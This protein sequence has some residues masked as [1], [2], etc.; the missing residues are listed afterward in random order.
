M[1]DYD[2]DGS[3]VRR[4]KD[5]AVMLIK[6]VLVRQAAS[7]SQ[8]FHLLVLGNLILG[9]HAFNLFEAIYHQ[10]EILIIRLEEQFHFDLG[11]SHEL[12]VIFADPVEFLQ[13]NTIFNAQL[14]PL[15]PL[16]VIIRVPDCKRMFDQGHQNIVE[17][18]PRKGAVRRDAE[19]PAKFV[20][21]TVD[22]PLFEDVAGEAFD[23]GGF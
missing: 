1:L 6:L 8:L 18:I 14:N 10:R 9:T 4:V 20:P 17:I 15:L 13:R 23:E 2:L 11:E 3:H 16:S 22:R 7:N 12:L 5:I 21:V 19:L